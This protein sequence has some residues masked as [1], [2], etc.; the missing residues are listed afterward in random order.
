MGAWG[1]GVFDDD[2]AL[3]V[4]DAY[5]QELVEGKSSAAAMRSVLKHLKEEFSDSD[6]GPTAWLALATAQWD[7]GRLDER[8]K[9]KA[10][11]ILDSEA[12]LD[13]WRESPKLLTKR[14]QGL[15]KL[16][17]QLMSPQPAEKEFRPQKS[18]RRSWE[19]WSL[20]EYFAYRLRQDEFV[21]LRVQSTYSYG[22]SFAIVRW[23][24]AEVPPLPKIPKLKVEDKGDFIAFAKKENDLPSDRLVRLGV[25]KKFKQT[26]WSGGGWLLRW[27]QVP[28]QIK[29]RLGL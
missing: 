8:T 23:H 16:R 12:G 2:V 21:L 3:D 7:V 5:R 10:L 18:S 25:S 1:F 9:A 6:D 20:G 4:R 26:H 27:T 11:K 19:S 29:K 24:G 28:H 15:A 22:V 17:K 14:R 13:R